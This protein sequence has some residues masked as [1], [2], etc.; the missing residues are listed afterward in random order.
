VKVK[1]TAKKDN[2]KGIASLKSPDP[3]IIPGPGKPFELGKKDDVAYIDLQFQSST[4]AKNNRLSLVQ[5][6]ADIG[7][8]SY[9]YDK[10]TIAYDHL[11]VISWFP[12]SEF[13]YLNID[14]KTAGRHLA[15]IQGAGDKIVES[16][17]LIG[18]SVDVLT[19][20]QLL[21]RDLSIYDAI[22]AG[23]RLYNVNSDVNKFNSRLM[24]Y[25]KN[26]G[27]YLVQ[28]NVNNGLKTSSIGPYPFKISNSRVTDETAPVTI[29]NG[30][31]PLLNYPNKITTKDFANWVQ[32]RGLY[33][34]T[35]FDK[36]YTSVF[37]MND[38]GE[39]EN[40]GSLIVADY[41]KGRFVY[42]SLSFFRQ[43][44]AGVPGAYRLFVN[45]IAKRQH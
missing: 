31:H 20:T 43:L 2:V 6:S 13:K 14:L 16:L 23:V 42:T 39:A 27:T 25:V 10:T 8:K 9:S 18:Y 5:L 24:E 26:G 12:Q 40:N 35:D 4:S 15:Y 19:E 1:I 37:G 7:G 21:S 41:G 28:Y 36:N 11:P 32:E 17:K 38:P 44:P 33:F 34:A 3:L 45:L 30:G 29:L 22:V